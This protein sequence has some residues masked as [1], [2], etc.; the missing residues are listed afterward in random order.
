MFAQQ[1]N[2]TMSKRKFNQSASQLVNGFKPTPKRSLKQL[3]QQLVMLGKRIGLDDD[4]IKTR[5]NRVC[6]H[7]SDA[8]I[9]RINSMPDVEVKNYADDLTK[10][11]ANFAKDMI[12]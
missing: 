11:F 9:T 3:P 6:S 4:D 8:E 2:E 7:M 10:Q 1:R 12:K 5:L